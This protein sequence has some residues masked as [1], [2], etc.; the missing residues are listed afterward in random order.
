VQ[1]TDISSLPIIQQSLSFS[2][3]AMIISIAIICFVLFFCWF[4]DV[5]A[6]R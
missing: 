4:F 3:G 5:I 6:T 1:E 2:S